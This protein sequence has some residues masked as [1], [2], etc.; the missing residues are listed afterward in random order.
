MEVRH[1]ESQ[2]FDGSPNAATFAAPIE[3]TEQLIVASVS[4]LEAFR[5]VCRDTVKQKRF[6][7]RR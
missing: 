4:V 7:P 3:A 5:W 1:R 6:E 2:R